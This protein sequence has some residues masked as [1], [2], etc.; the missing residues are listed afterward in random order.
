VNILQ[1]WKQSLSL[2]GPVPDIVQ[3]TLDT[4]KVLFTRW[5][6]IVIM[7]GFVALHYINIAISMSGDGDQWRFLWG[8]SRI[9]LEYMF[10]FVICVAAGQAAGIKDNAYFV[11]FLWHFI[12]LAIIFVGIRQIVWHFDLLH[13]QLDDPI[14]FYVMIFMRDAILY[15]MVF[16]YTLFFLDSDGSFGQLWHCAKHTSVMALYNMPLVIVISVLL[17]SLVTMLNGAHQAF[18]ITVW[19]VWLMSFLLYTPLMINVWVNIYTNIRREN[20][21]LYVD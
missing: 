10:V 2:F 8:I 16:L 1:S 4:Y 12:M 6:P 11:G 5:V 9:T 19:W 17:V 7:L 14:A 21:E 15:S 20:S 18:G 3:S 13:I